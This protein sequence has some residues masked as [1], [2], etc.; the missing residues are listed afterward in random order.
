MQEWTY[1]TVEDM[2]QSWV[3]RLCR[4][5]REPDLLVYLMR[6]TFM[7]ATRVW[8]KL[9]HRLEISGRENL[10]K[11]G[12]FVIVA[13]H[14]SHLDALSI[15][16]AL[17]LKKLHRAFPAAAADY[18]FTSIPRSA[19]SALIIN[20]LPFARKVNI[21][22][23]LH[24]C[25]TLLKNDGNILL[26]FPEGTR[27]QTGEMSEFKPGI[28]LLLSRIPVSAVPCYIAG[29]FKAWPKGRILP[30]PSR[31]RLSFGQPRTFRIREKNRGTAQDICRDLK[32]SV[33]ALVQ[34]KS[35]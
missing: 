24:L 7:L 6:S 20:A 4:F 14:T 34:M 10:P 18:F 1:D 2:D 33:L 15:L 32:T 22:Q 31:L 5:P 19:L 9:Y 23:S 25:E 8:L 27:T 16:S 26:L 28:G 17:P 13:N 30:I 21:R 11:D 35:S 29:G 3:Q 12:S